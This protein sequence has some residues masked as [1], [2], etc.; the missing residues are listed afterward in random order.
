MKEIDFVAHNREKWDGYQDITRHLAATPPDRLAQ[1]YL[2]VTADLAFAQTHFSE[3]ST[4]TYL[5]TL[6]LHFHQRLYQR[7]YERWREL[8]RFY[9][10]DIPLAFYHSRRELL[11][12]TLIFLFA[13]CVGIVSQ[14]ENPD[15]ARFI[16]GEI[17]VEKTEANIAGGKPMA[18][19]SSEDELT[20]F[21]MIF[22][23][24]V[25]IDFYTFLSGLGSFLFVIAVALNN[26]VMFGTFETFLIQKGEV[27][28]ALFVVNLHGSLEIPT[29]V[30]STAS[31]LSLG[32]GWLFPGAQS[33]LSAFRDGAK[34]AVKIFLGVVP[35][36]FV[37]A[38]I[39]SYFTRHTEVPLPAR[40]A[41]VVAGFSFILYY[42]VLLPQRLY[43]HEQTLSVSRSRGNDSRLL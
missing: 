16:L 33:R 6:A 36:T 24:N 9:T 38:F 35:I 3:S 37:A 29:I 42:V 20:M 28:S 17:Y 8:R 39:E 43:H 10:H 21:G 14:H 22:L 5:E 31:G 25:W 15:F 11:I 40:I 34:R 30:M 19:Y 13:M 26:G 1:I 27:L 41:F 23:N 7:R 32:T 2:D 18:V 4:T 12:A